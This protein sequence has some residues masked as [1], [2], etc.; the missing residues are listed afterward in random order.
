MFKIILLCLGGLALLLSG[1]FLGR[2]QKTSSWFTRILS[3]EGDLSSKRI[4][5]LY[6]TLCLGT[7]FLVKA[8]SGTTIESSLTD[9]LVMVIVLLA[10]ATNIDRAVE[11]LGSLKKKAVDNF[12]SPIQTPDNQGN[13]ADT[14]E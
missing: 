1:Y 6:L 9:G 8:F 3:S 7:V 11:T 12:T 14:G 13:K 5:M 2:Y 10:G 4:A